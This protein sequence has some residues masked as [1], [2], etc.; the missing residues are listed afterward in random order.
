[1]P[2]QGIFQNKPINNQYVFH[3]I[4]GLYEKFRL[5]TVSKLRCKHYNVRI[6]GNAKT[7]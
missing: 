2:K 6:Q 3:V 5:E 4:M 7:R 1:M